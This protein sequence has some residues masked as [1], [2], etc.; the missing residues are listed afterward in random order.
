MKLI[1]GNFN[2]NVIW[3]KKHAKISHSNILRELKEKESVSLYH[4]IYNEAQGKEVKNTFYIHKNKERK[5]HI[6]HC[7]CNK[8][9]VK[10]Y[11]VLDNLKYLNFS[12]HMP[13]LLELYD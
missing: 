4:E 8:K 13:L 10:N 5:Y 1:I 11:D 9:F 7:F 12:D 2:S 6:D 3:N